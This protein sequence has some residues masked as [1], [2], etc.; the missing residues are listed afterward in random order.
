MPYNLFEHRHRFAVWAA[1]R[2][3]QRGF[4]SIKILRA[5]LESTDIRRFV[6]KPDALDADDAAFEG[7]HRRWCTALMKRLQNDRVA[8]VSYGRV[9]KLIAVYLK[10]MIVVGP[11]ARSSLA[12]VAHPPIDRILLRNLAS[13][14]ANSQH[15]AKW[16]ATNW[17]TL[18]ERSYYVLIGELRGLLAKHDPFWEIER[19]WT[20]T[21]D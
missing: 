5:A 13:V 7:H 2:A 3:A 19:Y 8:N 6:Q 16:R 21:D 18:N 14:S 10:A 17:T 1:A 4:A 20:V 12:R 15:Q 11:H 9:A